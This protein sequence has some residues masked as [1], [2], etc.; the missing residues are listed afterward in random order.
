[1]ALTFILHFQ[2]FGLEGVLEFAF[3]GVLNL[4]GAL[5]LGF[6]FPNCSTESQAGCKQVPLWLRKP[7]FP[8]PRIS[9]SVRGFNSKVQQVPTLSRLFFKNYVLIRNKISKL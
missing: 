6:Q 4:H 1:M 5:G 9:F 2:K 7:G 8:R 3:D